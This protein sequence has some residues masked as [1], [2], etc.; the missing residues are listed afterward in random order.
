MFKN[1][2]DLSSTFNNSQMQCFAPSVEKLEVQVRSSQEDN[3]LTGDRSVS[4]CTFRICPR[5]VKFKSGESS[6]LM[7]TSGR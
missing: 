2:L 3:S 6:A 1:E 5:S 7:I 4:T